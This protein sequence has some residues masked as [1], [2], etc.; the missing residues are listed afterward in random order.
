MKAYGGVD[1]YIHCTGDWI[2]LRTAVDSVEERNLSFLCRESNL[3]SSMFQ[4]LARRYIG[5]Q[6][7]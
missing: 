1:E 4:S 6:V 5:S 2:I 3:V 7:A